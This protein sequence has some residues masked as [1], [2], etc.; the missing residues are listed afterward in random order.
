MIC[1]FRFLVFIL[2]LLWVLVLVGLWWGL[3]LFDCLI[4]C[5]G[6]W[7]VVGFVFCRFVVSFWIWYGVVIG[8]VGGWLFGE[9]VRG[10]MG[11][12][13]DSFICCGFVVLISLFG[14]FWCDGW[15]CFWFVGLWFV[16]CLISFRVV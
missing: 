3:V 15:C 4:G 5:L 16:L 1:L 6:L 14:V 7:F 2:W 13:F 10:L 11:F 8:W 12:C 9:F